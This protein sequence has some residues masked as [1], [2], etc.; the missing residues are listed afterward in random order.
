MDKLDP[1]KGLSLEGNPAENLKWFIQR[2]DLY[3]LATGK[4]N[5]PDDQKTALFL[6]LAGDDALRVYNTFEWAQP[7]DKNKLDS[8][9]EKFTTHCK[10]HTSQAFLRNR[11]FMRDQLEDETIDQYVT[12]LKLIAKD[13]EFKDLSDG[14]VRDRIIFGVKNETLREKNAQC[15][16]L[17]SNKSCGHMPCSRNKQETNR[18]HE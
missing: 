11:F 1:P 18:Q 3:L 4:V 14:L 13:C 8:V 5:K 6:T 16:R 9:K 10:S 15:P 2:F 7:D 17:R 12:E